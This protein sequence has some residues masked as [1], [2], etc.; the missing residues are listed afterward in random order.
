M[1][2]KCDC[3]GL[4]ICKICCRCS[5]NKTTLIPTLLPFEVVASESLIDKNQ[6][7][8]KKKKKKKLKLPPMVVC[9]DLTKITK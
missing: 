1:W 4:R 5:N 6:T 2:Q 8:A 9:G 3:K 7:T